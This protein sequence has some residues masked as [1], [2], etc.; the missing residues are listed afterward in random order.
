MKVSKSSKRSTKRK[1]NN[2]RRPKRRANRNVK[3]S[4]MITY[5]QTRPKPQTFVKTALYVVNGINSY[6]GLSIPITFLGGALASSMPDFSNITNLYNRYKMLKV[7]YTFSLSTTQPGNGL[8]GDRLPKMLIRYNYDSNLTTAGVLSALQD[9]VNVK[10]FQFT[11]D[12]TQFSYSYYPRCIEPVYLSGI[13]TGY[14]L[15]RQQ[16]IDCQYATV[17]HYGLMWYV[18]ALSTGLFLSYDITYHMA[19]K[20]S[21]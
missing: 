15:A 14:K 19:F 20:Y 12:K 5:N 13:S 3:V 10:S 4:Q 1:A 11:A 8:D 17:P 2:R 16:Y 6:T 18:D 9:G 21:D 7:T